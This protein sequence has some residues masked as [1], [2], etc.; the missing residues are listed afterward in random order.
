MFV[1]TAA[2]QHVDVELQRV[3]FSAMQRFADANKFVFDGVSGTCDVRFTLSPELIA[4]GSSASFLQRPS[5]QLYTSVCPQWQKV[6]Q[7]E[8]VNV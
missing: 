3:L 1:S 7:C 5:A 8:R 6:M 4:A 2:L